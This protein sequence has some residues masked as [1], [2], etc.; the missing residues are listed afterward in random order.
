MRS[1]S[2]MVVDPM[3]SKLADWLL[4]AKDEHT[5]FEQ[6]HG[7]DEHWEKWY[8]LFLRYRMDGLDKTISSGW[9]TLDTLS[10]AGVK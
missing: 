6:N 2:E 9:A 5:K 3:P 10:M 4:E 7:S 8:A 1:K